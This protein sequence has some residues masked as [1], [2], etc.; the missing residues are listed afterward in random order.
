MRDATKIDFMVGNN[1]YQGNMHKESNLEPLFPTMKSIVAASLIAGALA[2][3]S[4]SQCSDIYNNLQPPSGPG[5]WSGSYG[6][7]PDM[8]TTDIVLEEIN[9]DSGV[10]TWTGEGRFGAYEFKDIWECNHVA[11]TWKGTRFVFETGRDT[12][13]QDR[14]VH[15]LPTR[16]N[17][18]ALDGYE[19]E[20]C[21]DQDAFRFTSRMWDLSSDVI[22]MQRVA[23]PSE[24]VTV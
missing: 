5:C 1:G 14:C 23:C 13:G 18:R 24:S 20:F 7:G 21:P 3:D 12:T 6:S 2:L 16:L 11:Y 8:G 4:S 9:G 15:P 22:I 19:M 17:S 10:V